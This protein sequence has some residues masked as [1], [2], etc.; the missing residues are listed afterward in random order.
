MTKR[1]LF[2]SLLIF[3]SLVYSPIICEIS[4]DTPSSSISYEPPKNFVNN[5]NVQLNMFATNSQRNNV[6][7]DKNNNGGNIQSNSTAELIIGGGGDETSVSYTYIKLYIFNGFGNISINGIKFAGGRTV[8]LIE[9]DTYNICADPSYGCTFVRWLTNSGTISNETS[10]TTV[11][12]APYSNSS[13]SITM[14]IKS[15]YNCNNWAGMI[16]S[17]NSFSEVSASIQLP[18][19]IGYSQWKNPYGTISWGAP[20]TEIVVMWVGLGGYNDNSLWQAGIAIQYNSSS[21]NLPWIYAFYEYVSSNNNA[22]IIMHPIYG[23]KIPFGGSIYVSVSYSIIGYEYGWEKQM[24]HYSFSDCY[25]SISGS[26]LLGFFDPLDRSSSFTF[27]KPA[28]TTAEWITEDPTDNNFIMPSFSQTSFSN[29][30]TMYNGNNV[31]NYI[32]APIEIS[33]VDAHKYSYLTLNLNQYLNTN[34][35]NNIL[36]GFDDTYSYSLENYLL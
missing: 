6:S 7:N 14:V 36:N 17:G 1:Q 2:F 34:L 11:Y 5:H 4:N 27:F 24:G 26:V 15:D 3:V 18:N 19:C 32:Y 33:S 13:N 16:E 35:D 31:Y 8:S 21:T 10:S 25:G 9:G 12:T 23:Y 28:P 20:S 29:M 22:T 30:N